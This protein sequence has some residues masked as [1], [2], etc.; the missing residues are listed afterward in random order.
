NAGYH[1]HQ[2]QGQPQ[3]GIDGAIHHA[4]LQQYQYDCCIHQW[5]AMPSEQ[6]NTLRTA[7]RRGPRRAPA[8]PAP[9]ALP[10]SWA[11]SMSIRETAAGLQI[12]LISPLAVN[13]LDHDARAIVKAGMFRGAHAEYALRSRQILDVFN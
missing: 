7:P 8:R 4:I 11:G 5:E 3:Q 2:Y 6:K 1:E 13:D 12:W 10:A 9:A